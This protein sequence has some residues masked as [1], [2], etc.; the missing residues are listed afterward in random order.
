MPTKAAQMGDSRDFPS[1][2][3]N[4]GSPLMAQSLKQDRMVENRAKSTENDK[5]MAGDD[6]T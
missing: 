3:E 1:L 4:Q 5:E 6:A 2:K